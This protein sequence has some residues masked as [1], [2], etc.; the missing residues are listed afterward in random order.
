MVAA[1]RMAF[2]NAVTVY[3]PTALCDVCPLHQLNNL[4]QNLEGIVYVCVCVCVCVC[5]RVM[6]NYIIPF[7]KLHRCILV[8]THDV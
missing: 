6:Y 1:F 7:A 4:F 2:S 8:D 3:L 5:V